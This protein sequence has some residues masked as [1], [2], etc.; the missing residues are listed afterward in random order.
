[1]RASPTLPALNF[2][3]RPFSI[4][5]LGGVQSD[6]QWDVEAV[7]MLIIGL[8]V[9]ILAGI[10]ATVVLKHEL[11]NLRPADEKF[12]TFAIG[13]VFFHGAAVV[14]I[15]TFIKHH[16]VSW[17]DFIY[18]AVEK[19]SRL[20]FYGLAAGALMVPVAQGL[21]QVSEVLMAFLN[22][23]STPQPAIQVLQVA[24][25]LPQRICFGFATIVLVPLAEEALFRGVAYRAIRERGYPKTA[26]IVSSVLFGLIHVNL[27]ILVPLTLFAMLLAILYEKTG[28]LLAPVA[29]HSIFNAINFSYFIYTAK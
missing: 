17:G 15:H 9:S 23:G 27:A 1:Q 12:L 6:R 4:C 19:R 10:A 18:G 14:L 2:L 5:I 24:V 25:P 13:T 29:A 3:R 11:P 8:S 22:E 21:K 7:A 28:A 16:N 26:L 20:V